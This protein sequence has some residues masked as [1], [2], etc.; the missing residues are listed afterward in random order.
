MKEN[1]VDI[2]PLPEFIEKIE[3]TRNAEKIKG[4]LVLYL[5]HC[6]DLPPIDNKSC[7][8]KFKFRLGKTNKN[9]KTVERKSYHEYKEKF[10]FPLDYESAGKVPK[11]TIESMDANFM[12]NKPFGLNEVDL[13]EVFASPSNFIE[14]MFR[15]LLLQ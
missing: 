12:K 14:I 1:I 8:P 10:E 2:P 9:T 4:K 5:V 15:Y 6:K 11:L 7:D 3:E 13:S